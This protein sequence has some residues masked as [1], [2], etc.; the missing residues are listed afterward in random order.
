MSIKFRMIE[1]NPFTKVLD[2]QK[3]PF[4][5]CIIFSVYKFNTHIVGC[6]GNTWG[7]LFKL[8]FKILNSSHS[9]LIYRNNI[10][11]CISILC[12]E[13]LFTPLLA[14]EHFYK[15]FGIFYIFICEQ[16]QFYFIFSSLFAF[17]FFLFPYWLELPIQCWIGALRKYFL[18][19]FQLEIVHSDFHHAVWCYL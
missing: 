9:W 11:F 15:F 6:L 4:Y 12:P 8:V 13:I 1:K 18:S 5:Q 16:R 10:D 17:P 3:K 7:I 2:W 14:W 19:Y